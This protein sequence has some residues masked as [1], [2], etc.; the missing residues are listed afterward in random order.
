MRNILIFF[1]CFAFRSENPTA[2][3]KAAVS[4]L[5]LQ[6]LYFGG[7]EK[8][9]GKKEH[10]ELPRLLHEMMRNSWRC[11]IHGKWCTFLLI[12]LTIKPLLRKTRKYYE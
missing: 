5:V 11:C 3:W 10:T 2:V 8:T 12:T 1:T 4:T 7:K 9:T 6:S